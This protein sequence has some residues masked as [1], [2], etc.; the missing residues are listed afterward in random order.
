MNTVRIDEEL[1]QVLGLSMRTRSI[2]E[3]RRDLSQLA[4]RRIL[5]EAEPD[6]FLYRLND[7]ARI[8]TEG[9]ECLLEAGYWFKDAAGKWD[10]VGTTP[11]DPTTKQVSAAMIGRLKATAGMIIADV[12]NEFKVLTAINGVAVELSGAV[13][14]H[15]DG[16]DSVVQNVVKNALMKQGGDSGG[17]PGLEPKDVPQGYV[18][19]VS[20]GTTGKGTKKDA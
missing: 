8:Q 19:T 13:L 18:P 15:I 12:I 7:N 3:E 11:S 2:V 10:K 9:G 1:D 14:G 5:G 4:L 16:L 6:T 20:K 17:I